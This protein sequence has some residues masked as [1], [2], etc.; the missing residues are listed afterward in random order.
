V[1]GLL[2]VCVVFWAAPGRA[3]ERTVRVTIVADSADAGGLEAVFTELLA[4]LRVSLEV[5]RAPALDS[6]AFSPP[7][8]PT[9]EL[10][11]LVWVDLTKPNAATLYL[12]DVGTDRVLLRKIRREPDGTE[13]VQEELGHILQTSIEGLLAGEP[14]GVPRQEILPLLDAA[15]PRESAAPKPPERAEPLAK[16]A[17]PGSAEAAPAP[18]NAPAARGLRAHAMLLYSAGLLADD[19][20]ISHGPELGLLVRTAGGLETALWLSVQWRLPVEIT[21]G[22]VSVHYS[23][24]SPRALIIGKLVGNAERALRFGVGGGFDVVRIETTAE[25]DSPVEV[26]APMTRFYPI[27]RSALLFDWRIS[28]GLRLV[29][30]LGADIDVSN[31]RYVFVTRPQQRLLLEPYAV[32]PALALG[33]ATP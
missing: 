4:R 15:T 7:A 6:T 14:V 17:A 12:L 1:V 3:A 27:G 13:L 11:A 10:L 21:T 32:R 29:T 20:P 19:T 33:I 31:T 26:A 18:G 5:K 9:P 2:A 24:F 16:P 23:Q 8:T 22:P 30:A 28:G 25:P